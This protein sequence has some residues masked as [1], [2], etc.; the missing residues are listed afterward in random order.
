MSS[1]QGT[2]DQTDEV[3]SFGQRFVTRAGKVADRA[4]KVEATFGTIAMALAGL[5]AFLRGI[6]QLCELF[7]RKPEPQEASREGGPA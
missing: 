6:H 3:F 5:T 1:I 2:P 4:S 7:A